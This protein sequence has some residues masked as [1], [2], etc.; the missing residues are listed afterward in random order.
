VLQLRAVAGLAS[1]ARVLAGALFG[2]YVVVASGAYFVSGKVQRPAADIV[3]RPRSKMPI[4]AK[5]FRD[6]RLS[7]HQEEKRP[8]CEHDQGT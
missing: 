6:D 7:H 1:D 3:Q 4:L 5:P 2:H 8:S